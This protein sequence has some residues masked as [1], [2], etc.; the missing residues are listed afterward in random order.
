L[1]A[2]YC[3]VA[4]G[5]LYCWTPN[6]GYT[7]VMGDG[8][9]RRVRADEAANK[10]LAPSGYP[11][12]PYGGTQAVG[13]FTCTSRNDGLDCR[14]QTGYTWHLPRYKGLPDAYAPGGQWLGKID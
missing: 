1:R 13:S 8:A 5:S 2:A 11:L 3:R 10:G 12:L 9:P 6:D 4:A 7:F 14:S